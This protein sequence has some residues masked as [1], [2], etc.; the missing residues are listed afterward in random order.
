MPDDGPP[1]LIL[2]EGGENQT[3]A[4]PRTL[5]DL[6]ALI[7]RAADLNPVRRRDMLSSIRWVARAIG[8]PPE[9]IQAHMS[10]LQHPIKKLLPVNF[11]IGQSRWP[12]SARISLLLWRGLASRVSEPAPSRSTSSG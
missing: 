12:T 6:L 8:R 11:G 4:R 10:A 7:E 1:D 9:M 2:N 5:A 3:K